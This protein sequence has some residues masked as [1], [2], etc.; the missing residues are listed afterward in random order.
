MKQTKLRKHEE[1]IWTDFLKS[2]KYLCSYSLFIVTIISLM[3]H[4]FL[5]RTIYFSQNMN[6][7][8]VQ[9]DLNKKPTTYV[10]LYT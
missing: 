7:L 4:H 6:H 8:I 9:S 2:V 10:L 3:H 5:G 1:L